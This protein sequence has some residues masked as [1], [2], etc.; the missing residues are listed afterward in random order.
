LGD[1]NMNRR[2][3]WQKVLDC[4]VRRWSAMPWQQLVSELHDLQ[5]YEVELE[6]NT[7]AVEV[8]LIENTKRYLHVMVAV[9]DGSLPAS[10]KPLTETFI[11][12]KHPPGSSILHIVSIA[13]ALMCAVPLSALADRTPRAAGAGR[14][15]CRSSSRKSAAYSPSSA[16]IRSSCWRGSLLS[17]V[18]RPSTRQRGLRRE[19]CVL[20]R[21][22]RKC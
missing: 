18:C 20:P 15:R 16:L 5:A 11:C 7:Y 17:H 3:E 22:T 21:A 14:L 6:S 13:V 8:E 9:D 12:K 19:R 10:L 4:E 2:R 1:L